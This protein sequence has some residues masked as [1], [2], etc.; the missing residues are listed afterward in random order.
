MNRAKDADRLKEKPSLSVYAS[1]T[2]K[3]RTIRNPEGVAEPSQ[4]IPG[5]ISAISGSGDN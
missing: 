2:S 4:Q 1:G 3:D 5:V